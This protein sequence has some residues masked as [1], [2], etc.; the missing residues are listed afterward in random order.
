MVKNKEKIVLLEHK[1]DVI[2]IG[3]QRAG[4]TFLRSYFSHHPD[5]QWTRISD[6][7]EANEKFYSPGY[8]YWDPNA[9]KNTN[10]CVIDMY[11]AHATGFISGDKLE[12]LEDASFYIKKQINATL[13]RDYFYPAPEEIARRIKDTIP[14]AKI[15]LVL[16]NQVDWIRSNYLHRIVALPKRH[17]TFSDYISTR[18]GKTILFGGLFHDTVKIYYDLFGKDNVQV[19]LLEQFK[20]DR[21]AALKKMCRFLDVAFVEFPTDKEK[22]NKGFDNRVGNGIRKLSRLGLGISKSNSEG[23]ILI[24]LLS[25]LKFLD[26]DVLTNKEKAFIRSFYAASNCHTSE[27]LGIDLGAYGYPL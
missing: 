3:Y 16:R 6:Y 21:N 14:D 2:Y 15:L 27:L 4:S 7:F 23:H 12:E 19:L 5:I 1:P 9:D 25:K 13:H 24:R 18:I 26:G 20:R 17:K 11:E 8:L 22:R 10:K